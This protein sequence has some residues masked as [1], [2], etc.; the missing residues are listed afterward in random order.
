MKKE[1]LSEEEDEKISAILSMDDEEL[2]QELHIKEIDEFKEGEKVMG[3]I[4]YEW[5]SDPKP[6]ISNLV[7]EAKNNEVILRVKGNEINISNIVKDNAKLSDVDITSMILR[8]I[9]LATL[10]KTKVDETPHEEST[11]EE[12][13]GVDEEKAP[14]VEEPKLLGLKIKADE[15]SKRNVV[16]EFFSK[17]KAGLIEETK[18]S[19]MSFKHKGE[20]VWEVDCDTLESMDEDAQIKELDSR[21]KEL[22]NKEEK[23]ED[24]SK[25]D[26]KYM[27]LKDLVNMATSYYS[28]HPDV[29]N[30]FI[31]DGK[32]LNLNN[33]KDEKGSPLKG[34]DLEEA[35][36]NKCIEIVNEKA[37]GTEKGAEGKPVADG[38]AHD[39]KKSKEKKEKSADETGKKDES[40]GEST[41]SK[42]SDESTKTIVDVDEKLSEL[43]KLQLRLEDCNNISKVKLAEMKSTR[44]KIS[45]DS[46]NKR[47]DNAIKKLSVINAEVDNNKNDA[48]EHSNKI[49]ELAR[50]L[51]TLLNEGKIDETKKEKVSKALEKAKLNSE[52][53]EQINNNATDSHSINGSL[54]D[55]K[56]AKEAKTKLDKVT[57]GKISRSKEDGTTKE[58]DVK[59][60]DNH[61]VVDGNKLNKKDCERESDRIYGSLLG[62]SAIEVESCKSKSDLENLRDKKRRD[63]GHN[64]ADLLKLETAVKKGEIAGFTEDRMDELVAFKQKL[65]LIATLDKVSGKKHFE[66][67]NADAYKIFLE[68][69]EEQ[70][71]LREEAKEC[72]KNQLE[73][74]NKKEKLEKN[75]KRAKSVGVELLDYEETMSTYEEEI[76]NQKENRKRINDQRD[77]L[78]E[79]CARFVE[80]MGRMFKNAKIGKGLVDV[81]NNI[82]LYEAIIQAMNPDGRLTESE[83]IGLMMD[84]SKKLGG[85]LTEIKVTKD[86]DEEL[87]R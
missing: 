79:K 68:K 61:V 55:I 52:I 75:K 50:E 20:I 57:T 9:T 86:K 76:N 31:L 84:V 56:A 19:K 58:V 82:L 3:K 70:S 16:V 28:V 71:R 22:E 6:L 66:L 24:K 5:S 25:K 73:S 4:V 8:E 37:K 65:F 40:K 62:I 34:K 72:R 63:F 45:V 59:I 15:L 42:P 78:I 1:E 7:N 11:T 77:C 35:V 12:K 41:E 81:E 27:K 18:P 2:K 21:I 32:S 54:F 83:K 23:D 10:N 67:P 64:L 69:K 17:L 51:E 43:E 80:G 14:V 48:L 60:E 74:Q 85:D 49:N 30:T 26:V 38:K 33:F 87:D 36:L 39:D 46:S 44:D 29:F 53:V 47:I 13:P